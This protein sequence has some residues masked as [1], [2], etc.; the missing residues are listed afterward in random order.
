[1]KKSI[2]LVADTGGEIRFTVPVQMLRDVNLILEI[3]LGVWIRWEVDPE[4]KIVCGRRG[5]EGNPASTKIHVKQSK[6]QQFRVSIPKAIVAACRLQAG[7]ICLWEWD[8]N[9]FEALI[10]IPP[11]KKV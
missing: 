4:Q 10:G 9:G 5:G 8:E 1:M 11:R 6:S 7:M 2:R 3:E